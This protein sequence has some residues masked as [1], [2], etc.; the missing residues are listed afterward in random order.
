M[1]SAIY[2]KGYASLTNIRK[3]EWNNRYYYYHTFISCGILY[4][5]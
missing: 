2:F 1:I 3:I 4:L 5:F